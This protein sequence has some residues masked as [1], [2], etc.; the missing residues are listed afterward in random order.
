M[1]F[2]PQNGL[3]Q[4]SLGPRCKVL[5]IPLLVPLLP[6]DGGAVWLRSS[7]IVET[8]GSG[9][10]MNRCPRAPGGH[11]LQLLLHEWQKGVKWYTCT[12]HTR[13]SIA[14]EVISEHKKYQNVWRL[15]LCPRPHWGSLQRSPGALTGREGAGSL[16]LP[17]TPLRSQPFELWPIGPLN[18]GPQL[19][20]DPGP[21]EPCYAT[22]ALS[23]HCFWLYE[24]DAHPAYI[25]LEVWHL[26]YFSRL[27][28]MYLSGGSNAPFLCGKQ[29]TFEGGMREPAIAWWPG[30]IKPGQVLVSHYWRH[31]SFVTVARRS[32]HE[33]RFSVVVKVRGFKVEVATR[34]YVKNFGN[35]HLLNS[36][37]YFDQILY[38]YTT[39]W[40]DEPLPFEGHV[41][42]VKVALC[43]S[44]FGGRRHPH[45]CSGVEPI[46]SLRLFSY[47]LV[48]IAAATDFS[49]LFIVIFPDLYNKRRYVCLFVPYGQP[50]GW[51]D[52]DQTWHTHSC[53]PREC[54]WQGQCQG[55][56]RMRA[57]LTE[58]RNTR[59]AT[60]S[61]RCSHYVWTTAATPSERL[62]NAVEL[63]V[64]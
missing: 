56:S 9:G 61:E 44:Y 59:N 31:Y 50:N 25:A 37:K 2:L 12:V 42:K 53:P 23:M 49:W 17:K 47:I 55:H 15:G 28:P 6:K 45:Q 52:R 16:L 8:G 46:V 13:F 19:T 63:Q 34:S 24:R 4:E 30:V 54:F 38:R 20:V 60:P 14:G 11:E 41:V 48:L 58:V 57:G 36:L 51:A 33:A 26:V 39:L 3:D 5:H 10:S 29:T 21:P 1:L 64:E 7:G 27:C 40:F 35:P 32:W 18:W 62:R 22:A 43:M